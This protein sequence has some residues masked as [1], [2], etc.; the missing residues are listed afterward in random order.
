M[1]RL[2]E[3]LDGKAML[4]VKDGKMS[5]HI[6]L[7]GKK[8][9][10]LYCG[11]AEDAKN[12]QANWLKPT[13]DTVTYDDGSTDQVFGFDIPLT[14]EK[15][16]KDF[17]LALIGK[18]GIWYDHKVCVKLA[19][20][21]ENEL[22]SALELKYANQFSVK[23]IKDSRCRYISL[24]NNQNFVL[25]PE[26]EELPKNLPS[27]VI[28]LKQPLDKTYLVSTS[29]MDLLAK[30]G[31]VDK[32]KFSGTRQDDWYIDEAVNAMQGGKLLYAGKYSAPDYELLLSQGCN[33]AIQNTMI[34]HKP[35]VLEK[36]NELGIPL[37]VEYSTY[38]KNPLGRLEWI[39]LYG[40]LF[41]KEKQANQFFEEQVAKIQPVLNKKNTGKSVAFF[42]I[43]KNGAVNVRKT[44]DYI[45]RMIEMAGGKY[46]PAQI[47][48]RKDGS[49]K[50]M[51]GTSNIQMEDFFASASNADIIIYNG[52]VDGELASIDELIKKNAAFKDFKAVQN[53]KVYTSQ[54]KFFQM[55]CGLGD[56]IIDVNKIL[57]GK[58]K[59]LTFIEKVE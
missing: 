32:L 12:D 21:F 42:Y 6:T 26:G 19:D 20:N 46:F 49:V 13:V 29:V 3:V 57:A 15:L 5:A 10:N 30:I 59:D 35:E 44:D 33:F 54:K 47:I 58:N 4:T 8:I 28:V 23:K 31:A 27:D 25:Q 9:V 48:E 50:S 56:F 17:D 52:T 40:L 18:K 55:S 41:G 39:K 11:K 2:N 43:N 16:G 36:L 51:G 53:K 22:E 38:E 37:L 7:T 14:K 1:F 34:Y 45:A 24:P